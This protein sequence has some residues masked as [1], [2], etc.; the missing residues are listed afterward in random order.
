MYINITD[1][2]E[3]N[4]KG[5]C[6]SLVNY[7]EK[8]NR[9][10]LADAP[11]LWFGHN[12]AEF[13]PF[14]VRKGIDANVAKLGRRDAKFYLINISP[15]Q[16]ELYHLEE[17][18]GKNGMSEALKSYVEKV[19]DE[20][21]R[22]FNRPGIN[23]NEDLLW[24]AKLEHHRHYS[25][26]D[27]EVKEGA[28]KK[29]EL[30]LGDQRHIQIIVSRKDIANKVKLSPM[31]ASRGKNV[32]HSKKMGQF[33]RTAFKRCG[34]MV[35]DWE[36]E[37]ERGLKDRMDYAN[38]QKNG[39]IEQRKQ[40]D[41]LT[42]GANMHEDPKGI[43]PK[44][45]VEISNGLFQ[46]AGLMLEHVGTTAPRFLDIMLEPV[47]MPIAQEPNPMFKKKKKTNEKDQSQQL[48]R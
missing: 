19:M 1:K 46:S 8:E 27:R 48:S 33:D 40:L 18:F 43:I 30:K 2:K 35:F 34:E 29:G 31:N 44:L 7:L 16:K 24:F 17:M 15:S 11:E 10:H 9:M 22:N 26:N 36:F 38:I 25:H 13:E 12:G 45:A 39:T 28:R 20:Y 42:A 47:H 5:S 37:F 6:S 23:S 32:E 4:N 21:A 14:E 41:I 3:A